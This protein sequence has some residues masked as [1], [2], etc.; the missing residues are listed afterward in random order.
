MAKKRKKTKKKSSSSGKSLSMTNYIKQ[1][2]RKLKVLECLAIPGWEESGLAQIVV[3]RQKPNGAILAGIYVVD[4]FCLGIKDTLYQIFDFEDD[5][6]DFI[7]MNLN[8]N[9]EMIEIEP[10]LAFNLIYGAREYAEDLGFEP[11]RDFKLTE[12]ILP[13]VEDI[14][15]IDIEFGKDGKP[16]YMSGPFD[17]VDKIL[18]T[19]SKNVGADNFEF[20]AHE[21]E[22]DVF[23][24]MD[25]DINQYIPMEVVVA[26]SE[27]MNEE[28][29]MAYQI[30]IFITGGILKQIEGDFN[31][32][33]DTPDF[34]DEM[35][36]N[37]LYN[38]ER[39]KLFVDD[40]VNELEE[41]I[42]RNVVFILEKML[43]HQNIAFLLE[44]NYLPVPRELTEEEFKKMSDEE[45]LV[46]TESVSKTMTREENSQLAFEQTFLMFLEEDVEKGI[47]TPKSIKDADD[48]FEG[49]IEKL[50]ELIFEEEGIGEELKI[51]L[52]E[53]FDSVL[54]KFLEENDLKK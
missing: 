32:L 3:A 44:E 13:D 29:Q 46:Y 35:I 49:K 30:Q 7:D 15:Y 43:E 16:F 2:A 36:E 33:E 41:F 42:E 24:E 12:Y 54:E 1:A 52:R 37:V 25:S 26:K 5:Y 23:E 51:V 6:R 50:G 20:V 34:F 22:N 48:Y 17:N 21:D 39:S 31:K 45:Y 28:N 47:E 9:G 38:M 14:E 27:K 11:H 19:L 18:N 8:K 10:Q 4:I 53:Y 40:M